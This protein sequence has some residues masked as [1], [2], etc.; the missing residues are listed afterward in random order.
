MANYV[1]INIKCNSKADCTAKK[2]AIQ[3]WL[4]NEIKYVYSKKDNLKKSYIK[5]HQTEQLSI[6]FSN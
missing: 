6:P 3:S 1:P 4:K 2:V 5:T